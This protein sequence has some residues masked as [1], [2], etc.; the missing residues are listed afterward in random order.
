MDILLSGYNI[1]NGQNM[2]LKLDLHKMDQLNME[3]GVLFKMKIM[4]GIYSYSSRSKT[5]S[6]RRIQTITKG[7]YHSSSA[8][9]PP[10]QLEDR[11]KPVLWTPYPHITDG[12][13]EEKVVNCWVLHTAG[14]SG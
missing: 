6:C 8:T 9:P 11:S 14:Q 7:G 12:N 2:G 5:C 13:G 3:L 4:G 10:P 1:N